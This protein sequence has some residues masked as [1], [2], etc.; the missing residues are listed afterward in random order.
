[1]AASMVIHLE[2]PESLAVAALMVWQRETFGARERE[3]HQN[4]F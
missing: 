4:L 3:L 1:M 2:E